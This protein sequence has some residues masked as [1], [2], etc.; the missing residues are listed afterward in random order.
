MIFSFLFCNC[1]IQSSVVRIQLVFIKTSKSI[2]LLK[3]N[4]KKVE[5]GV[6]SVDE[7]YE[8]L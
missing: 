7:Y 5:I 8:M 6:V 3:S 2:G 1:F 4:L